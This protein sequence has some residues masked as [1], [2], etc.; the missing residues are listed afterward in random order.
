MDTHQAMQ[1]FHSVFLINDAGEHPPAY[2]LVSQADIQQGRWKFNPEIARSLEISEAYGQE[3]LGHYVRQL[4]AGGKYDLTI[5]PYHAMLGGI[6]HALVSSIEEAIFF[7]SMARYSQP[8][9]QI[10][11]DNPFTENY[12]V[13]SPEV[14]TDS[15]GKE[16]AHK[17]SEFIKKLTEFDAVI[18]AGQAKSRC[19]F[20]GVMHQKLRF[21]AHWKTTRKLSQ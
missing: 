9:F 16:V 20:P 7:H 4:K 5:W 8:S 10:K 6:G 17:N 3:Y 14:L 19:E 12:S 21:G 1:I 15:A 18:I 2:T 13:L 11:G